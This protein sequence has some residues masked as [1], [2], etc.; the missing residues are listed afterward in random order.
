MHT[1]YDVLG[2]GKHATDQQIEAGYQAQL[3][4]LKQGASR[5]SPDEDINQ[6]K[7]IKEAY[8]IL[9]SPQRRQAYDAKLCGAGR[10][11]YTVMEAES[12]SSRKY[13]AIL[14]LVVAVLGGFFYKAHLDKAKREQAV[15][16][17]AKAQADAEKAELV[18]KEEEAKLERARLW[19]QQQAEAIQRSQT[20]QARYEGQRIHDQLNSVD[21]QAALERER[22]ERQAKYDAAREEQAAKARSREETYR[23][24]RALAI[25]I[26]RH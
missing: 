7:V 12:P 21:R 14:A 8:S 9:S 20:E 25:P 2:L 6:L 11:P 5:G 3:D 16:E 22:A 23:M 26:R 17:A 1:L 4:A 24:E 10:V 13:L 18:A 15:L 19:Q